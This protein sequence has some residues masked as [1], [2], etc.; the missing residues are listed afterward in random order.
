MTLWNTCVFLTV[1]DWSWLYPY[2]T[3]GALA[4]LT[5]VA[6]QML[7]ERRSPRGRH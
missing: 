6:V 1:D 2:V 3:G 5:Y 7:G 4:A